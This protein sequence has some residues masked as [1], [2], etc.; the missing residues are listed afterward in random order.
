MRPARCEET[1]MQFER[2]VPVAIS[3]A[4]LCAA[5]E[6]GAEEKKERC[7]KRIAVPPVEPTEAPVFFVQPAR[8]VTK[9]RAHIYTQ[10]HTHILGCAFEVATLTRA[11][12][13]VYASS[14]LLSAAYLPD[15]L[16]HSNH[17]L[18]FC[19]CFVAFYTHGITIIIPITHNSPTNYL[20]TI[21]SEE[22]K[23]GEFY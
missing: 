2:T 23:N 22:K 13:A 9:S 8:L 16:R 10:T 7:K 15:V 20:N 12:R 18:H 1:R 3:G 17:L 4:Y 5:T 11:L 6:H 19:L 21:T 14:L